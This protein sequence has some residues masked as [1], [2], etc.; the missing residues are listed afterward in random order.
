MYVN[1]TI[2]KVKKVKSDQIKSTLVLQQTPTRIK[3]KID[4]KQR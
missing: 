2:T 3:R 4:Y 1:V